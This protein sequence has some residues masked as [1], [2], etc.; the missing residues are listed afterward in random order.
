[1]P[2]TGANNGLTLADYR[3]VDYDDES[4]ED[5]LDQLTISDMQ[6]LVAFG[7]YQTA[8]ADSVGKALTTDVDGPSALNNNFTGVG[9]IG[10]ACAVMIANTWNEDL[11][12]VFG[13]GIGTMAEEMNVNGWYAPAVNTHRSPFTGRN[14]EYYS[15]DGFLAGK[16]SSQAVKGAAEHGVYAYIKHFALNE[17]ETNRW[18]KLTTWATEQAIRE[19]YLKP[20][21]ILVK[22]GEAHAVM[23]S[24]NYIGNQWAGAS[25]SLLNTVLRDEWGFEGFTLTDYFANF[26]Y[27]SM[28][29]A[30]YN[31]GDTALATV[32]QGSNIVTDT[33]N[34]QMVVNMRRA[35]KNIMF[36]VVNSNA[37]AEGAQN[38]GLLMYQIVLITVDIIVAALI[39]LLE[40]LVVRKGYKKRKEA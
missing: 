36:T 16:L 17:M 2:T 28:D 7:G 21:E 6:N 13:D 27:M 9:S 8:A 39:V 25:S 11:S 5:L 3:G 10:Y 29:R 26:D 18:G 15:E 37:Y 31:G 32:D 34:A 1:M 33:D 38:T 14:F 40:L 4:W 35:A 30:L 20:F 24:Y 22:E 23:T 19:N 12:Y